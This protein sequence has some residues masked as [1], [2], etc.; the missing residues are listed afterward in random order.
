MA[1][2]NTDVNLSP[3]YGVT[4]T[5]KPVKKVQRYADGYEH[6]LVFGVAA[7]QN[8]RFVTLQF[9]DITETESDTLITFLKARDADNASFDFTPPSDIAGKFV[10]DGDYPK[11]INYAG[12]ASVSVTFREVFEP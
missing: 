2:F 12:L 10:I 5:Q 7:H 3:N 4:I 11:R 6:R 9:N 1:N 8:P